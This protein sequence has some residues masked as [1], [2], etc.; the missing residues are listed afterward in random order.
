[1]QAIVVYSA[2]MRDDVRELAFETPR[3]P[4]RLLAHHPISLRTMNWL[5]DTWNSL[6]APT[7]WSL[8]AVSL[9]V[10]VAVSSGIGIHNGFVYDD[11]YLIQ[12]NGT[13]HTLHQWWRLFARSYW[14]T[15]YGSDGYRPIT[16]LAFSAEW[17]IG[18]GSPVI[19][20]AAQ[21]HKS[22][23]CFLRMLSA[24]GK[25]VMLRLRAAQTLSSRL[26]ELTYAP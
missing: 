19:F 11:V 13:V 12:R 2:A 8:L 14:P 26:S 17:V 24:A 23:T 4:R 10:L 7:R 22:R 18:K 16:M 3:A 25:G 6:S 5:L 21:R 15:F 9:L 20:H 1:L